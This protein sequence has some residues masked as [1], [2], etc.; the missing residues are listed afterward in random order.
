MFNRLMAVFNEYQRDDLV[1]TMQQGK[2]GQARRGKMVPGRYAPFGFEYDRNTRSYTLNE[3]RMIHVRRMFRMVAEEGVSLRGVKHAFEADGILTVGGKRW[4]PSTV[5][6]MILNDVYLPHTRAELEDLAAKGNLAP[7]L[8][9]TFDPERSYGIQWYSRNKWETDGEGHRIVTELPRDEWIAIP[10]PDARVP[11][12][13]VEVAREAIKD[14]VR[15]E[16][17]PRRVPR[18]TPVRRSAQSGSG[19]TTKG[20]PQT[21]P[22]RASGALHAPSR[23][24]PRASPM[25][26][27]SGRRTGSR[28]WPSRQLR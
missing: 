7:E 8:L 5:R 14:N 6:E 20:S 15:L 16:S 23:A 2:R 9:A 19:P 25:R 28:G 21:R 13:H 27:A 12:E 4:H 26:A 11:R 17:P 24:C 22:R 3:S 18:R 10:T 1:A